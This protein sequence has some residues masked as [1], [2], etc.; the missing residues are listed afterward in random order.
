[1]VVS[2]W[3]VVSKCFTPKKTCSSKTTGGCLRN[4]FVST[5]SWFY[6]FLYVSDLNMEKN[7]LN[8][9]YLLLKPLCFGPWLGLP[10]PFSWPMQQPEL[11][12]GICWAA[13]CGLC[14]WISIRK[15]ILRSVQQGATGWVWQFFGWREYVLVVASTNQLALLIHFHSLQGLRCFILIHLAGFWRFGM[16]R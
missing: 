10:V 14:G 16:V 12:H 7:K 3:S 2:K 4:Y 9:V 1:M 5:H 11:Q 13:L 8:P 15:G 6:H